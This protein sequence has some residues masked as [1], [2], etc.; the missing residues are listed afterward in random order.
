M[1]FS[2]LT[3]HTRAR[4]KSV[5]FD[6]ARALF[7]STESLDVNDPFLPVRPSSVPVHSIPGTRSVNL[8]VEHQENVPSIR[9]YKS[10]LDVDEA[11]KLPATKPMTYDELHVELLPDHAPTPATRA[12]EIAKYWKSSHTSP[13]VPRFHHGIVTGY[14]CS[15]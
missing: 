9:R 2:D 12:L 14:V 3:R 6:M 11:P 4:T 10:M 5:Q 15:V 13:L 8:N 7:G 1:H